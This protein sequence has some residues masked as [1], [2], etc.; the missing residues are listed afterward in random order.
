MRIYIASERFKDAIEL[1]AKLSPRIKPEFE[2]I[3]SV[4]PK[5]TVQSPAPRALIDYANFQIDDEIYAGDLSCQ[6][7][8]VKSFTAGISPDSLRSDSLTN[9]RREPIQLFETAML[10]AKAAHANEAEAE[11]AANLI[12]CFRSGSWGWSCQ[13]GASKEFLDKYPEAARKA[14]FK[15]LKKELGKTEA[16]RNQKYWF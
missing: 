1:G 12:N 15:R 8:E 13:G 3:E 6:Q 4:L 10:E 14:L 2:K 11:A 5:L 7:G 9:Y 16:G